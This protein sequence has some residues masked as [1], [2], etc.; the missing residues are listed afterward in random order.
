MA[1]LDF[2]K[3][4]TQWLTDNTGMDWNTVQRDPGLAAKRLMGGEVSPYQ[5]QPQPTQNN[6]L[7]TPENIVPNPEMQNRMTYN[8]PQSDAEFFPDY[9]TVQND[10]NFDYTPT[11]DGGYNLP[12][13]TFEDKAENA[14]ANDSSLYGNYQDTNGY[15]RNRKEAQVL[16]YGNRVTY[17]NLPQTKADYQTGLEAEDKLYGDYPMLGF[18]EISPYRRADKPIPGGQEEFELTNAAT[19]KNDNTAA[20]KEV[21]DGIKRD[22][23][24]EQ[25]VPSLLTSKP[26]PLDAAYN[27]F[28]NTTPDTATKEISWLDSLLGDDGS[29]VNL[30]QFDKTNEFNPND[31][32]S[33]NSGEQGV[34]DTIVNFGRGI[35][36]DEGGEVDS[37]DQ[38][39]VNTA[40]AE[41]KD[42]L[43]LR[44]NTE[45]AIQIDALDVPDARKIELYNQKGIPVPDK[46]GMK[47]LISKK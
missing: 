2:M 19:A 16:D 26:R 3:Q 9:R 23:I 44:K 28:T 10:T 37:I 8:S 17:Q 46:Y 5:A 29:V 45:I 27:Q 21:E 4:G 18:T 11:I 13:R 33:G 1:L 25:N 31:G 20:D 30:D 24:K 6:L 43:Q 47:G 36:T 40:P 38:T 41:R 7:A 14:R 39:L 15:D 32:A 35:G 34:W 42:Y 12:I 22:L